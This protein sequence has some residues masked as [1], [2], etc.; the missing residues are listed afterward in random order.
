MSRNTSLRVVRPDY[1]DPITNAVIRLQALNRSLR[2]TTTPELFFPLKTIFQ[3]MESLGSARIEGNRTTIDDLVDAQLEGETTLDEKIKEISNIGKAT[4][5]IE[6]EI[7]P[8]SDITHSVIREAHRIIV[9]GLTDEGDPNPGQY[10]VSEVSIA[11]S[12]HVPPLHTEVFN[13]M[14]ELLDFINSA[15]RIQDELLVVAIAHHRFAWIHP[16][17]NG[18]GRTV[19][20]LTYAMLIQQGFNVVQGR[21]INPGAVFFSDREAYYNNLER[22]DSGEDEALLDWTRYVLLGLA[23]ELEKIE[24]LLEHEYLLEKIL[25]PAIKKCRGR[26][27]ISADE[28]RILL[29]AAE[30]KYVAARHVGKIMASV[31]RQTVARRIRALR[32]RNMLCKSVHKA[33]HYR[34]DFTNNDLTRA[35][36]SQ[37]QQE[38]FFEGLDN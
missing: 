1:D 11:N 28:E 35:V 15:C 10:R 18:N 7:K 9:D 19:R 24:N 32:D 4:D 6:G 22:A 26:G 27:Q 20:L 8:G 37:L 14:Q 3:W 5:F 33:S 34:I 31:S 25:V 36:V 17:R 12:K 21:I 23:N 2:G 13:Y 16:F 38:G 30:K 29:L